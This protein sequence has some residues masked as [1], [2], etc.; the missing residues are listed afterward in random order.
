MH[1]NHKHGYGKG[2]VGFLIGYGLLPFWASWAFVFISGGHSTG[3]EGW[4]IL[5]GLIYSSGTLFIAGITL[6]KHTNADGDPFRK[7]AVAAKWFGVLNALPIA[8]AGLWW[9]RVQSLNRDIETERDRALEVVRSHETVVQRYGP[10]LNLVVSD[11]RTNPETGPLPQK[12]AVAIRTYDPESKKFMHRFAIVSVKESAGQR[13]LVLD[14][15]T[16]PPASQEHVD[17]FKLPCKQ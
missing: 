15:I 14:C 6:R 8:I 4:V 2:A 1:V 13:H 9:L 5:L 3:A 16:P 10:N 17:P 12:Y 7:K 11:S